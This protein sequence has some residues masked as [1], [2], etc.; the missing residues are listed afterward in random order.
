[1]FW[2][3]KLK[4]VEDTDSSWVLSYG[5]FV[6]LLLSVFVMIAAMSEVKP[7]AFKRVSGGVRQA[8]GF[9][10]MGPMAA[11]PRLRQPPTLLERLEQA[12]FAHQSQ[13]RL[14]GPDDEVLAPCDLLIEG[15][16]MVLRIAGHA[17]FSRHNAVLQPAAD[18]A[19]R[20][21]AEFLADR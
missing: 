17:S 16:Q 13:L 4:Q 7:E 15:D 11:S 1:M 12:G 8:F 5:D 20:R 10:A 6:T 14:V 19:L 18:R 2:A 3:R 9:A 21:L